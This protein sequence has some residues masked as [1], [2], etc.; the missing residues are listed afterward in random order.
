MLNYKVYI[1]L[2]LKQ[3]LIF[4]INTLF[5]NYNTIHII[6]NRTLI[7]LNIY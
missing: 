5:N 6:N 1:T 2:F 3:H 4:L 7:S